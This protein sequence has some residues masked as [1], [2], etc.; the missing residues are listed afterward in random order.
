[1]SIMGMSPKTIAIQAGVTA[2]VVMGIR[3]AAKANS[4]VRRVTNSS[5]GGGGGIL[6]WLPFVG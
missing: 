3:E 6:S 4:T 5:A 1:M 2:A